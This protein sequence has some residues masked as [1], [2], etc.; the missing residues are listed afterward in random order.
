MLLIIEKVIILKSTNL[1]SQISQNDLL[2]IATTLKEIEL[3]KE[4]TI[5]KQGEFGTSMY[6]IVR[7]SVKVDVN[8]NIVAT[9]GKDNVFGELAVL[10]P[11]PRSATI[12]TA[13]D[14]LLFEID[15]D[16]IYH[17]ISEYPNVARGIMKI[18][19]NKLRNT[20]LKK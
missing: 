18:L 1:F 7:G 16:T 19:C 20:T 3:P 5:M 6:I 2:A 10:D 12:I 9:L 4:T 13:E 11:E 15:N 17:I 8:G 14:T